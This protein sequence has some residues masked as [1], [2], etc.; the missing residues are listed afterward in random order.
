MPKRHLQS[1]AELKI[2]IIQMEN[3]LREKRK[4]LALTET[5]EELMMER[6][7]KLITDSDDEE[8][9]DTNG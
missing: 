8:T 2:E 9:N 1:S 4:L 6:S 3:R 5:M 7:L